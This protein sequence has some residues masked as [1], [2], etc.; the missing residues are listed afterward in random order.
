MINAVQPDLAVL[1]GDLISHERDP[2]EDGIAELSRL[3]V[4]LGVWGCHGNHERWAGV[5]ARTQALFARD[6]M[7][8]LRQQCVELSWRGGRFN[9]LGVDDQ[10][11]RARPGEPSSMLRS[12]EALVRRDIPNILLSH[13]PD[14]FPRAAALGIE[15]SLAGHTHGGQI[16]FALGKRQW[17]PASL[18][19]PF[20]AGLYRLP[21]GHAGHASSEETAA[22]PRKSAFLYVNPGLGTL[23]LPVRLGVPP[24]IT[25]LTLR[26]AG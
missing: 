4:P 5:E 21:L 12:I 13:N 1:T 18:I 2:L 6:G 11:E 10:R 26:A 22:C 3:R 24:E 25:V 20:V 8:V 19:T 17:S 7:H 9:L 14:T 23:G 15:L 16:R